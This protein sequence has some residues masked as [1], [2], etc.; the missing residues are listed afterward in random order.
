MNGVSKSALTSQL[1]T[2]GRGNTVKKLHCIH[3]Q[4]RSCV[5]ISDTCVKMDQ[6][7]DIDK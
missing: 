4:C 7:L 2:G 3:Q 6:I 1:A 5:C